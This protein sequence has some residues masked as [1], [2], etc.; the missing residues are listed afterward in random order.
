[1]KFSDFLKV[2]IES[3]REDMNKQKDPELRLMISK[4]LD[5]LIV[6]YYREVRINGK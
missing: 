1:M 5:I 2:F 6:E 4:L 3:V